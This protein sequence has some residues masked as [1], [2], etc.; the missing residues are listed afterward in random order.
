MGIKTISEEVVSFVSLNVHYCNLP[1]KRQPG[2]LIESL[3]NARSAE[4]RRLKIDRCSAM[5]EWHI[6]KISSV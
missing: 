1:T 6:S 3:C 5:N 4:V 2:Q